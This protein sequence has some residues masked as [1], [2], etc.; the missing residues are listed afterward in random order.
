MPYALQSIDGQPMPGTT[1]VFRL[2]QNELGSVTLSCRYRRRGN[3][4]ALNLVRIDTD[5]TVK[6]WQ[7]NCDI[8]GI[9]QLFN[10]PF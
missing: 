7:D 10:V 2:S 6:T 3:E 9:Q 1:R 8:V 5:G 4:A